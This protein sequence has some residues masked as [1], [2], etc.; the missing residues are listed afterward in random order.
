MMTGLAAL[1]VSSVDV[2]LC[3]QFASII[4]PASIPMVRRMQSS[5]LQPSAALL[6]ATMIAAAVPDVI[7][8]SQCSRATSGWLTSH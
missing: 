1:T 7:D 3:C 6:K 5:S 2:A 4:P 8:R